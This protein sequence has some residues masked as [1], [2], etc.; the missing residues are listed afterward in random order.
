MDEPRTDSSMGRSRALAL[1]LI[2]VALA[3]PLAGCGGDEEDSAA[4]ET[5]TTETTDTTEAP[6]TT[7]TTTGATTDTGGAPSGGTLS[8][9]VGPGFDIGMSTGGTVVAGS[10]ALSVE[11]LSSA[12][13]FHLTGPGVDVTTSVAGEGTETFSID[14]QPGTYEFVCDPHAFSMNGS[15]EVT[16]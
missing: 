14:L 5:T 12:H 8:G 13:N 2:V 10:Y 11:D 6:E 15:F 1:G 16:G 3:L 7:E 4:P 9:T